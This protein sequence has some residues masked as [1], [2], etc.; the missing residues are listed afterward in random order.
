MDCSVCQQPYRTPLFR[1]DLCGIVAAAAGGAETTTT[2]VPN[3]FV[4][5]TTQ[6]ILLLAT[7][8]NYPMDGGTPREALHTTR[9]QH[10][11]R[12]QNFSFHHALYPQNNTQQDLYHKGRDSKQTG[13]TSVLFD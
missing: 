11:A 9:I 3:F 10:S 8:W 2:E 6:L 4:V 13:Y 5:S 12:R 7:Q 1:V